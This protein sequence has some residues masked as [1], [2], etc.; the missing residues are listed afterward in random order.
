MKSTMESTYTAVREISPFEKDFINENVSTSCLTLFQVGLRA[1]PMKK[2]Y[3][4]SASPELTRSAKKRKLRTQKKGKTRNNEN[5]RN[6]TQTE[7]DMRKLY[8][9][10]ST[11]NADD[12]NYGTNVRLHD[13][14]DI[15]KTFR[16]ETHN[17][18]RVART[19]Q[20]EEEELE[21]ETMVSL[22]SEQILTK[23]VINDIFQEK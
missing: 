13:K 23:A 1:S 6:Q 15:E 3:Q 8:N 5:W 14:L 16:S 12:E 9:L 22:I 21:N 20:Q 10:H 18:V 7:D 11:L 19:I 17:R 2:P 4:K